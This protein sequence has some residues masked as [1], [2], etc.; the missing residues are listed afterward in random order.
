MENLASA[1][2]ESPEQPK[3]KHVFAS[4]YEE[5]NVQE[6]IEKHEKEGWVLEDQFVRKDDSETLGFDLFFQTTE[7]MKS[8]PER[9]KE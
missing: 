2:T 6:V 1:L 7:S 8:Y 5:G 4:S 3:T 9:Q